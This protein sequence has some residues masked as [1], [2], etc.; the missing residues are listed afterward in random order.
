MGMLHVPL[1]EL[2]RSFP[3]LFRAMKRVKDVTKTLFGQLPLKIAA[4]RLPLRMFFGSG[5]FC[6]KLDIKF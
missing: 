3:R 6:K 4:R 1:K 2:I 5:E